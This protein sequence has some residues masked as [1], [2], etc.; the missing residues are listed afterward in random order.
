MGNLFLV[1]EIKGG[2]NLLCC[3]RLSLSTKMKDAKS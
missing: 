2:E 1:D 3:P